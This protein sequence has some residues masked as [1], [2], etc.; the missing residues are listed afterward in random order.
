MK[1]I[2]EVI[3]ISCILFIG[4]K[5]YVETIE[6]NNSFFDLQL[7]DTTGIRNDGSSYVKVLFINKKDSLKKG[8]NV[9]FETQRGV[10]LN[11]A[12]MV[13]TVK[14]TVETY[15]KV[16]QDTGLYYIKATLKDGTTQ[17]LQKY[18]KFNLLGAQPDSIIYEVDNSKLSLTTPL[19]IKTILL[20]RTGQ[21]SLNSKVSIKAF[22]VNGANDT[23]FVGRFQ[24]VLGNGSDASGKL[25]DIKFYSDS[26]NIDISRE[27]VILISSVNDFKQPIL[28][29]IKLSY[30]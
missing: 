16:A 7:A 17:V 11:S 4:C 25:G 8:L 29:V 20:R 3:L 18:L 5:K 19:T 1:K 30:N 22:Q 24:N 26:K 14:D 12:F 28:S 21:V 23:V 9:S 6:D 2:A 15:L 10:L 13:S 27:L